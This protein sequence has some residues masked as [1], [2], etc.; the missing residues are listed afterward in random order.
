MLKRLDT[1]NPVYVLAAVLLCTVIIY[2]PA[3]DGL[4][5]LDDQQNLKDLAEIEARGMGFYLFGSNAGPGG[6]PLALLSFALQ[7]QSW[8]ADAFAFKLVNLLLHL[9]N[10]ALIFYICLLL[11]PTLKLNRSACLALALPVTALWLLH[12]LQLSTVLYVVQRMTI[13][14]TFFMLI[15]II[16]YLTGRKRYLQQGRPATALL[17]LAGVW[18]CMIL[19]TASKESG[20]LLPLFIL[21]LEFTL[22]TPPGAGQ[23]WREYLVPLLLL[24]LL[25]FMIYIMRGGIEGL[26]ASYSGKDFSLTER[27]LTE[28]NV[29]LD[30]LRL[31]LIPTSGSFS[32]FHDDYRIARGLL[33][34]PMTLFSVV[35]IILLLVSALVLR[36]RARIY[37][38]AVLWF[39]AGHV[40]ESSIINLELYFEHRNYLPLL[41]PLIFVIWGLGKLSD[42]IVSGTVR[43]GIVPLYMLVILTVTLLETGLWSDPYLQAH[44]WARQHPQSKRAVNHLLDINLILGRHVEAGELIT[45]LQGLDNRDIFPVIKEIT[46]RSCYNGET[47]I[48]TDWNQY[49]MAAE[50]ANYRNLGVISGIENIVYLYAHKHCD[51]LEVEGMTGFIDTLIDNPDFGYVRGELHDNAATFA[52]FRGDLDTALAHLN[53]SL[54]IAP[55]IDRKIFKL[56]ILTARREL[57]QATQLLQ[58][59]RQQLQGMPRQLLFFRGMITDIEQEMLA[60]AG[61]QNNVNDGEHGLE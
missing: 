59:I 55:D 13:L 34:P 54:A 29:L 47:I 33:D 51:E 14:A 1:L 18:S 43:K 8:P 46:I 24:P 49:N 39:F 5:L 48:G 32:L 58:D 36:R 7:Y 38:F 53:S 21:V 42:R 6:R 56:R 41:G 44:E 45:R 40:L 30:Y 9:G 10:G 28:A 4:F 3:L 35:M 37:S 12:P 57:T 15:G 25:L 50:S 16:V 11:C 52:V 26:L 19:A 60:A 31:I 23:R 17:T 27:L 2:Y 61:T 20:I 22:L